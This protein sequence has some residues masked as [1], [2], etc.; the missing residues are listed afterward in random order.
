[1]PACNYELLYKRK[2]DSVHTSTLLLHNQMQTNMIEA[3]PA[4]RRGI[5]T[6]SSFVFRLT[7][8]AT[9]LRRQ[10]LNT[11][12]RRY[13]I[14]GRRSPYLAHDTPTLEI[15]L[16]RRA[17]QYALQESIQN[18]ARCKQA[19]NMSKVVFGFMPCCSSKRVDDAY[20]RWQHQHVT[21]HR[22]KNLSII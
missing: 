7:C 6:R 10:P 15:S 19:T 21:N 4:P 17:R 13:V 22:P 11:C 18:S 12:L 9:R 2:A 16:L 8:T 5:R 1:M 14:S 20:H 3:C